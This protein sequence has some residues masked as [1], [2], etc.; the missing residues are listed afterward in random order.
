MH[1]SAE[2]SLKQVDVN[3]EKPNLERG[4]RVLNKCLVCHTVEAGQT[5][6]AGPNLYGV[7]GRKVGK[8]E[9]Y[10]F[11]RALRKSEEI[12]TKE[13]LDEFVASPAEAIPRNRMAFSGLK[14]VTDRASLIKA[15][16]SLGE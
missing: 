12:W 13:L 11:S 14:N 6:A 15:L 8:V 9:G 16:E 3:N 2:D 10:K 5:H 1:V 4:L 7:L